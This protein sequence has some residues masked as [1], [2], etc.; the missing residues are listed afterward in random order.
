MNM[1]TVE[2]A[3]EAWDRLHK[4]QSPELTAAVDRMRLLALSCAVE[5]LDYLPVVSRE[6]AKPFAADLELILAA[7]GARL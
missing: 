7:L 2:E 3:L 1:P 5:G 4:P 6:N